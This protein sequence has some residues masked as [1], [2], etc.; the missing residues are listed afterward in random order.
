M[1]TTDYLIDI[2]LIALVILQVRGRRLS[3]RNLLIP[4]G[5]VTWVA[6]SYLHGVP[7][8]GNDLA[9]VALFAGTGTALGLGAGLLTRVRSG[10]D[11]IVAKAG[12]AAA[13]LWILGVGTRLAFQLY[14]SHG[15]GA[16]IAHFSTRH[17]ITSTEA[18]VAALILMAMGEALA[19]TAV[20][21]TRAYRLRARRGGL[22]PAWQRPGLVTV[23]DGRR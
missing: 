13:V 9:L 8:A 22:L 2:G 23:E 5:L 10:P 12:A 21:A 19:R 20:I 18:W 17:D 7:T 14:A 15:G 16:A 4:V 11:G 6:A 3:A 1:T